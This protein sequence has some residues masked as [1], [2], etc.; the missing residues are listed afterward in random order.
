MAPVAESSVISK[1]LTLDEALIDLF[2]LFYFFDIIYPGPLHG[3]LFFSQ[4]NVLDIKDRQKVPDVVT[5]TLAAL[6]HVDTN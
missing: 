1:N 5:R 4:H 3:L 2:S 6:Q